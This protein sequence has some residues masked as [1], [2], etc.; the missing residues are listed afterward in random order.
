MS[1]VTVI[2]GNSQFVIDKD[3]LRSNLPATPSMIRNDVLDVSQLFSDQINTPEMRSWANDGFHFIFSRLEAH[4]TLDG[5]VH[6][7][8]EDIEG[9]YDQQ[10]F[11]TKVSTV[12]K[13][14]VLTMGMCVILS[15]RGGLGS[16][17]SFQMHV[18]A[19]VCDLIPLLQETGDLDAPVK[20]G[21][22]F[23][24]VL[25]LHIL[26]GSH[27]MRYLR[28]SWRKMGRQAQ[29]EVIDTIRAQPDVAGREE[30]MAILS[31]VRGEGD[32]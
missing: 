24:K 12:N 19:F 25:G 15:P 30:T 21:Q 28:E 14:A 23:A 18:A 5:I 26:H 9:V 16:T 17:V 7:A 10:V 4:G 31:G 27:S 1:K 11:S 13:W 29:D 6:Y 2:V 32:Q 8:R 22:L 3:E 20:I